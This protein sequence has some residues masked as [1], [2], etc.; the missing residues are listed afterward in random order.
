MSP[1]DY[2]AGNPVKMVDPDGRKSTKAFDSWADDMVA[3]AD[4]KLKDPDLSEDMKQEYENAKSEL[5]ALRDPKNPVTY[6]VVYFKSDGNDKYNPFPEGY[7]GAY[8]AF[9]VFNRKKGDH[10]TVEIWL[11]EY[12]ESTKSGPID[13]RAN[14]GD[15]AH[16]AKHGH[17]F[18]V[19]EMSF[20]LNGN[21][22][23]LYDFTDEEAAHKRGSAFGGSGSITYGMYK[24]LNRQSQSVNSNT[25]DYLRHHP[26]EL[27]KVMPPC[28]IEFFMYNGK[29]V[30]FFNKKT[31]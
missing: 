16:E 12:I 14:L 25:I 26:T 13:L 6:D 3:Y 10:G 4:E 23:D 28:K 15:F 7:R 17:Q 21:P 31:K 22:G 30:D 9:T 29:I 20:T 27:G 2:C 18:H 8:K 24:G 5:E 11:N 19:G 1:Y